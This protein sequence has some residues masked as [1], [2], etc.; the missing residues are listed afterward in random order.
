MYKNLKKFRESLGMTQKEFASSL[1]IGHTTYNGYETGARD[2]KS[3]FWLS[4]ASKYGVTIDYLMGF[5]ENPAKT[6]DNPA[7][8]EAAA[9]QK[10]ED[11]TVNLYNYLNQG[12]ISFGFISET[13]DITDQEAEILISV[14]RILSATFDKR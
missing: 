5:S 13:G 11:L 2:P 1:G 10:E 7:V 9:E 8:A 14:A 4:V 6:K 3:D 12:L